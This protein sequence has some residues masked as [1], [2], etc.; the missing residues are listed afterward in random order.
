[1]AGNVYLGFMTNS[2]TKTVL[3]RHY[4]ELVCLLFIVRYVRGRNCSGRIN[5]DEGMI[6]E[7]I[8]KKYEMRMW[9]RFEWH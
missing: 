4:M 3:E 7:E 1:V 8:L 5:E 9:T 2:P 6:T